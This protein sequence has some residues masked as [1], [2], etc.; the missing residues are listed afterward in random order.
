MRAKQW[1]D[2]AINIVLFEAAEESDGDGPPFRSAPFSGGERNR[3]FMR[4]DGNFDEMSLVSGADFRQDG[5][6]FALL[7]YDRDGF[8]DMAIVSPNKPRFRI[9][10]NLIGERLGESEGK[11]NRFVEIE[12]IGGQKSSVPSSE[13]SSRDP[14]GAK[15]LV[16]TGDTHRVFQ[17][18]CGEGI[19]SQNS[20]Q[21]HVGLGE[22][23]KIDSIEVTWPSG[24]TTKRV[25]V[26][27][28]S[29]IKICEDE[30]DDK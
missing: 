21:I 11:R 13:W 10:K 2:G 16:T 7:D 20:K 23:E 3:L 29:R 5:R 14:I 17:L 1:G 9:V 27:P 24:K 18:S 30:T 4:R 8:M 12:L 26:S 25:D 22:A 15:I 6:G 28:S 19:S